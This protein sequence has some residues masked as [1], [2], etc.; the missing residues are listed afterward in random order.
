ME[1]AD[2]PTNE[3]GRY[4]TLRTVGGGMRQ[5]VLV[6]LGLL[7][8]IPTPT[9]AQPNHGINNPFGI[10]EGYWRPQATQE[11]GVSWNRL[12]FE[13]SRLQ[14]EGPGDFVMD[15][16]RPEWLLY[17]IENQ[18]EIVGL[19]INTPVWASKSGLPS[20]VPD[21]LYLPPENPENYWAVFLRQ[22]VNTYAPLGI[23]RWVIWN[24]PDLPN[25]FDGEMKDYYRL[26]KVAY[27]TIKAVDDQAQI[28][29]G[30]LAWWDDIG[31]GREP[32]LSRFLN[33]ALSDPTAPNH[34]FYFDG[35]ALNITI[36]PFPIHGLNNSTDTV[37]D[38]TS[39]VRRILN[40]ANLG[41]K[42][43]WVTELNAV[44]TLDINGGLPHAPVDINLQQQVDFIVQASALALAAGAERI[45]IGKL[46]DSNY[47]TGETIPLGLIRPDNSKRPAFDAYRYVISTFSGFEAVSVGRTP[48]GRLV[49]F[50]FPEH[51]VYVMWSAATQPVSYWIE[52]TYS[53]S[54]TL[55]DGAG[56]LK[57]S[58]RYGVGPGSRTVLVV[59]TEPATPNLAGTIYVS[60]SPLIL[61]LHTSEKRQ[62]WASLGDATGVK[63][64]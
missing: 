14:P 64:H 25:T 13:W 27:L 22:L 50:D 11:L 41:D 42:A 63:I 20:A 33:M 24:N 52:A 47:V 32:F 46:F 60:G 44:P 1:R 54:F 16:V 57:P 45:A 10:V 2:N 53:D 18:R 34:G 48:N 38:I 5:V 19:I 59:E 17:D 3:R 28:W 49:V 55:T 35:I 37:G 26:V 40:E 7:I 58:P 21:G 23:H 8:C 36:Q 43:I 15:A 4:T 6:L 9:I 61:T 56:N 29:T 31:A 62:V 51:S 12:T 39:T 30:G